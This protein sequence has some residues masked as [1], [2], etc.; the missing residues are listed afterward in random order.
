MIWIRIRPALFGF[1]PQHES[2]R[3]RQDYYCAIGR[4]KWLDKA[5]RRI[6]TRVAYEWSLQLGMQCNVSNGSRT[7]YV[8]W[9]LFSIVLANRDMQPC[10]Y[11]KKK[12]CNKE[13]SQ[14]ECKSEILAVSILPGG[15]CWHFLDNMYLKDKMNS[16]VTQYF[17]YQF[18]IIYRKELYFEEFTA[19]FFKRELERHADTSF[20]W[21][22]DRGVMGV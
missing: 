20:Q 7:R 14:S 16:K 15:Y 5:Q 3:H 22:T 8:G 13:Q 2:I 21:R 17:L 19:L 12:I 6:Q 4:H 18:H 10:T 1:R 9:N 11:D